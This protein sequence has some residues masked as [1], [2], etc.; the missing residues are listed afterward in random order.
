MSYLVVLHP[1]ARKELDRLE[2]RDFQ[3]VNAAIAS[4]SS[5]PR[6]FGVYKLK[7]NTHRIRAGRW[8]VIYAVF[9]KDRKVVVLRVTRR[10]EQTYKFLDR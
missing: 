8:R 2:G 4:L 9:D 10:N 6:P 5:N 7:E 3:A 1:A